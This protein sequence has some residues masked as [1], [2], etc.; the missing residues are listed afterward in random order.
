MGGLFEAPKPKITI[1]PAAPPPAAPAPSPEAE[2]S[3]ARLENR[4][5][6]TRGL[7]GTIATSARGLLG[8]MPD[9]LTTRRSLLGE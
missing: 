1:Q 5:R 6:T 9:F 7:P 3:Q 4:E 8:S 2:A